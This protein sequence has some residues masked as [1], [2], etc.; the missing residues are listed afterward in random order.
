[1]RFLRSRFITHLPTINHAAANKITI[2]Q[3]VLTVN[4]VIINLG[5]NQTQENLVTTVIY[6]ILAATIGVNDHH[7][8]I[9]EIVFFLDNIINCQSNLIA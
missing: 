4:F 3:K 9:Y 6:E 7:F 5:M 1:M 8:L 2:H